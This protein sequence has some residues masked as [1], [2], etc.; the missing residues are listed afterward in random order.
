MMKGIIRDSIPRFA[1][2]SGTMG[3]RSGGGE[4]ISSSRPGH[5][6][7]GLTLG[8]LSSGGHVKP[9]PGYGGGK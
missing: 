3:G 9:E 7:M 6:G 1:R 5:W 2:S 8:D 4:L